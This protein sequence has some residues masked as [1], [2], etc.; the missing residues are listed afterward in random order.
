MLFTL[1]NNSVLYEALLNRDPAFEGRAYVGVRST[2]VF[3]RLTCPARKPKQ[4][5][6]CFFET[7]A[8]C[9]EAGF[10]P[11]KRCHPVG[12]SAENDDTLLKLL[13]LFEAR[14]HHKL[15]EGDIVELGFDPSTVRRS[16]KRQFGVTFLEMARQSR[17]REG[18]EILTDGGKVIDAQ[19]ASGFSSSGAFRDAFTKLLGCTPGK[20]KEDAFLKA[21]WFDTP[22]GAMIAVSDKS[23][24]HLL[25][26]A[27]RKALPTE[28]N[29]LRKQVKGELGLG[30]TAPTDQVEAELREFFNGSRLDFHVPLAM[31]GTEFTKD[32]WRELRRI[33]VGTTRS[34]SELAK[35]LGRP[36]SS[37]AVAR[38]NGANQIAVVIPCHRVL[39]LDGSLTGYGGGL[40]R[41]Q[42][43][44]DLEMKIA[45]LKRTE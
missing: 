6:C 23:S 43:L 32:V 5:N 18:F 36:S 15:T 24:L 20:L 19:L 31:H 3:C 14:P 25:E 12:T 2:G 17:L 34:Y 1:P 45:K 11:C 38:A 26:F 22:L 13:T 30:R 7:T 8:E 16:F 33:P 10:R 42:K 39:G 41:K 35:L 9:F 27:D 37:R 28:L 29:R 40:W 4:E 44:I 21:D